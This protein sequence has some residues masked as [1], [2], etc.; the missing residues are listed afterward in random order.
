MLTITARSI[1]L[2]RTSKP[3]LL[4]RIRQSLS[5]Y[6]NFSHGWGWR[7]S[8]EWPAGVG[9]IQ[10][11]VTLREPSD[12]TVGKYCPGFM[13][14]SFSMISDTE[15]DLCLLLP[16]CWRNSF[17]MSWRFGSCESIRVEGSSLTKLRSCSTLDASSLLSAAESST[18][19]WG[20]LLPSWSVSAVDIGICSN[21]SSCSTL[22]TAAS[23][24]FV[25]LEFILKWTV[26]VGFANGTLQG[27][28]WVAWSADFSVQF[29][30][31]PE[32][33]KLGAAGSGIGSYPN[34]K[35]C[36]PVSVSLRK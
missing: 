25:N 24:S 5:Q 15:W 16:C 29:C 3:C 28:L 8:W 13:F 6:F 2:T 30:V 36:L 35:L 12:R 23:S 14:S 4:P 27:S 18:F 21:P 26:V 34:G 9:F 10:T 19:S 1:L 32:C 7:K 11:V 20:S 31:S 22:T 33:P 17:V